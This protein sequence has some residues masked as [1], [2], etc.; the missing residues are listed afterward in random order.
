MHFGEVSVSGFAMC[1]QLTRLTPGPGNEA[2][3]ACPQLDAD[4]EET[5]EED[6]QDGSGRW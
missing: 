1:E 6:K 3:S 4:I 2:R 5:K